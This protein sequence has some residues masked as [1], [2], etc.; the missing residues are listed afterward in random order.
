[1][2]KDIS[3]IIRTKNEEKHIGYCVSKSAVVQMTRYLAVHLAP[4]FRV[5]CVA[6]GGVTFKPTNEHSKPNETR[7]RN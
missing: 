5:N 6:P 7:E 3:V 2:D 4:D 1:M